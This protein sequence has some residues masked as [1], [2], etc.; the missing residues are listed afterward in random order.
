MGDTVISFIEQPDTILYN[1]AEELNQVVRTVSFYLSP[2]TEFY[3]TDFYY[4]LNDSLADSA[5]TETD[6]VNFKVELVREQTGAVAGTFDDVTYTKQQ[7]D[8]HENVSYQVDCSNISTGDYYLRLVTAVN[9]Y[10]EYFLGNVQN[11]GEN[12]DKKNYQKINFDGT[13]LPKSYELSQNFPNPFNPSTTIRYQIPK[14]GNVSLKVYDILGSEAATLV[15]EFKETGRYEV[16]FVVSSLAS[17]V[18]IYRLQA[19]EFV[20]V[21]KMIVIK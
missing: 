20:D 11:N 18:Y 19:D 10:S 8:R 2:S 17:G 3:F 9:G 4:V 7:L 15:D 6:L 13:K 1:S 14:A 16:N 5:L 21:K 12:L